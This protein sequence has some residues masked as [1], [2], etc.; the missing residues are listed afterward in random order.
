MRRQR[1]GT[2]KECPPTRLGT[3]RNLSSECSKLSCCRQPRRNELV[4]INEGLDNTIE[5][6]ES[7]SCFASPQLRQP[8]LTK[9][10][11]DY[12]WRNRIQ[13]A[14]KGSVNLLN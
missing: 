4:E 13:R 5:V 7:T 8:A 3:S 2:S 14:D 12:H 1:G 11:V 9:A 6:D 10:S